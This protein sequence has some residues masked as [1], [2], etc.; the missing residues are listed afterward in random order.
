LIG[1]DEWE[2]LNDVSELAHGYVQRDKVK[3]GNCVPQPLTN[4]NGLDRTS[5]RL[6]DR[7]H[8]LAAMGVSM[9][10]IQSLVTLQDSGVSAATTGRWISAASP[11]RTSQ[12]AVLI[13]GCVIKLRGEPPWRD[14]SS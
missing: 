10:A 5:R 11:F 8:L 3:L 6:A 14:C 7:A 2:K 1:L 4:R 12:F 13:K 9:Q